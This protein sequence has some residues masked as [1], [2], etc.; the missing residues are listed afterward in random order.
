MRPGGLLLVSFHE[1]RGELHEEKVWGTPV[2]FVCSLFAPDEVASSMEKAGFSVAEVTTRRPYEIEY[3]TKRV[4]I[5]ADT[6]YE[7]RNRRAAPNH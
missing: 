6:G 7:R 1:G 3:P 4:Y 2:S 5:L